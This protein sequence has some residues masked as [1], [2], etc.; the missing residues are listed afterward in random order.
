MDSTLR[1]F[2]LL[3]DGYVYVSAGVSYEIWWGVKQRDA[4][5]M[6]RRLELKHELFVLSSCSIR[7]VK[8]PIKSLWNSN[9]KFSL[10]RMRNQER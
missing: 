9:H 6:V 2:G 4:L 10:A 5:R 3:A 8:N 7:K 1:R